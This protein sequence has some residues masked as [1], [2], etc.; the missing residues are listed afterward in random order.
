[1]SNENRRKLLK[2]LAIGSGAVIA[3]KSLPENWTKPVVSSVLLPAHAQT[4]GLI[5][6][7]SDL[8]YANMDRDSI[9]AS[10]ISTANAGE[11]RPS[12]DRGCATL[13]A[14]GELEI[15]TQFRSNANRRRGVLK[16]DGTVGTLTVIE[17]HPNCGDRDLAARVLEFNQNSGFILDMDRERSPLYFPIVSS[18]DMMSWPDLNDDT[19]D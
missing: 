2:S 10:F 18:C 8:L 16:T 5:Y 12:G 1:M 13:L 17:S 4:S 15:Y 3:G 6:G 14:S 11:V 9:F 19:C 7:G